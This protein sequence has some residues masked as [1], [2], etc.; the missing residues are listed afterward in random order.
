MKEN[1]LYNELEKIS[2]LNEFSPKVK[3][4]LLGLGK[5]KKFNKNQIA[6]N[7]GDLCNSFDVVIEGI[8]AS[9]SLSSNDNE[10]VMFNFTPNTFMGGN[11]LFANKPLYPMSIYAQENS[12]IFCLNKEEIISLLDFKEFALFFI[13]SI[14][15]NAQNLNKKIVKYTQNTLRDN[16]IEYLQELCVIQRTNNVILPLTKKELAIVFGVQRQSLFREMKKMKDEG[17]IEYENKKI[18]LLI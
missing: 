14:S 9:Y 7:K 18:H 2:F 15:K 8:L 5:I 16:I 3:T 13:I 4:A 6:Y 12:I 1:I 17:I 10:N 11:L